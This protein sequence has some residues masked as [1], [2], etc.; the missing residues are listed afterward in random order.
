M[1]YFDTEDGCSLYYETEAFASSRPIVVFL[2]GAMQTTVYWRTLASM[3]KDRFRVLMYD[4][5]AQGQSDLGE[6]ELSLDV[7]A[8]DLAALLEHI[9]IE[10]VHLVGLSLGAKVAL[11][12]AARSPEGVDRLVLCS[13]SEALGFRARLI[14]RSWLEIL[15][16]SG[17]EAMAWVALPVTFGEDFLKRNKRMLD[18]IVRGIVTRNRREALSAQLKAV[19]TCPPVSEIIR[20]IHSPCLVISGSDDPLVTQDGARQLA[21]LCNGRHEHI[22]G[23]GHSVPA[24]APELF[25][26]IITEFLQKS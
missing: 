25:R 5:R 16:H 26:E 9:G 13:I 4:A 1:P 24:E 19:M 12:Y 22:S 23:V 20:N 14:I 21:A 2:N 15:T 7:H 10:R 6:Q 18:S 11:A 17:L 3:F 8:A